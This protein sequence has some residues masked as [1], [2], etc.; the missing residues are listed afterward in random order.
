MAPRQLVQNNLSRWQ[1]FH[2]RICPVYDINI[3]FTQAE[4]GRFPKAILVRN[5]MF[6]LLRV[7]HSVLFLNTFID[8]VNLLPAANPD[9]VAIETHVAKFWPF[10]RNVG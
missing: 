3:L 5:R 9:S 7:L 6:G 8:C 1:E 2:L 10:S 4:P